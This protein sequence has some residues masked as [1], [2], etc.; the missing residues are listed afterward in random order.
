MPRHVIGGQY[1]N[2]Y[3]AAAVGM[4]IAVLFIVSVVL[5]RA[6]SARADTGM[7]SGYL[8]CIDSAGVPPRQHAEDWSPT[9]NVIEFNLNN[10]ESPAEVAQKLAAMPSMGVK[11]NDA[12]AEVQC[13]MA[14]LW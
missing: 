8:R 14:N 13:V 3:L 12:L 4:A 5:T 9:I 1:M 11:P 2:R 10:A 6:S 7:M